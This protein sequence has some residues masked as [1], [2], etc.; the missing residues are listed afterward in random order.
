MM[1]LSCLP[2]EVLTSQDH[3]TISTADY[4]NG[5]STDRGLANEQSLVILQLNDNNSFRG[6]KATK[7]NSL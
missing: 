7:K 6:D 3:P 5:G 1:P 2:M 4:H